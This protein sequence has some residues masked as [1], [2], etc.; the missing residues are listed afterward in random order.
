MPGER[1]AHDLGCAFRDHV[2]ALVAP[3]AFDRQGL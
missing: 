3:E 2:A 1:H